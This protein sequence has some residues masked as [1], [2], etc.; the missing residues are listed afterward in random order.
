MHWGGQIHWNELPT[1]M[2][3]PPLAQGFGEHGLIGWLFM[4]IGKSHVL[5]VKLGGHLQMK[6]PRPS[7][8]QTPLFKHLKLEI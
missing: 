5:P 4:F 1:G 2:H 3:W 7:D 8:T 6:L